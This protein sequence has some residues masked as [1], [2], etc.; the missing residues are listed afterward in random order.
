ML[1]VA[2]RVL[3]PH[4]G[5]HGVNLYKYAH[6]LTWTKVPPELHPDRNHG[7]LVWSDLQLPPP[8]NRI[9]SYLDIVVPD[10]VPH[11]ALCERLARLKQ[12]LA[13]TA[14][15]SEWTLEPMWIRFGLGNDRIPWNT[16]LAALAAHLVLRLPATQAA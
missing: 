6:D 14:N 8:G 5:R 1:L 11:S 3:A 16:E 13:W 4:T 10:D 15:P 12:L 9:V 2:Q 7:R